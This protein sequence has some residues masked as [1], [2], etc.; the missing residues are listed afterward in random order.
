MVMERAVILEGART[1]IG[2]F[3][4]SLSEVPAVDLGIHATKAALSRARVAPEDADELVFGHARQARPATATSLPILPP[5]RTRRQPMQS[6]Y[7]T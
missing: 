3:L 7:V 5:A 4:G 1:P 2:R 6:A